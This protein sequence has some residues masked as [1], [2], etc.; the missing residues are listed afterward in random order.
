MN[1]ARKRRETVRFR[2][3]IAKVLRLKS[4]STSVSQCVSDTLREC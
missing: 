4:I 1:I 3:S 2:T